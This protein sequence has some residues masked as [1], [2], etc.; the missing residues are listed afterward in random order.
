MSDAPLLSIRDLTVEFG[1]APALRGISLDVHPGE[2]VGM[3]G[4]SGC[5]K[6]V[7]W[8][9][10]LGLLPRTARTRGSVTLQGEEMLGAR[11]SRLD[12][13]RGGRVAM[14]FQDPASSLNPVQR[15]GRQIA[16]AL[17]L[18]QGMTGAT[19][20][21][22][23]KRLLDQVG[24]PDAQRRLD[25]YPHELSGGQNQR[26]M[27]AMAL[28][29]RP[30]LLVADEPT[31][32]LDVTIQ[33]QILDLLQALRRERNMA[34]VL[35]TH[36]L[37]VVAENCE[38]VAV[39]YA[40]RI[41]EEAPV[42]QLFDAPAHPYTQGLLDALPPLYGERGPLAAIPGGVPEPWAMPP[43]CAFAP[44]CAR[45]RPTCTFQVPALTRLRGPH[46]AAC[47]LAQPVLELA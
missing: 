20:R 10:A 24:M 6:S 2:A 37:G 39:M 29:G 28:A 27:I 23:A 34:L 25:A 16:E 30:E 46:R 7:T 31:T 44:R 42:A 17:T 3:V 15:I 47:L 35:I 5:G 18:H 32:A 40:G 36:D 8:L 26:V 12:H 33:A 22:E 4:E 9:A 14:I 11:P 21:A 1:G 45:A 41:V 19:A 43:G 38:R 13:L